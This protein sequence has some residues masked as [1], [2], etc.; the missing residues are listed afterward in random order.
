MFAGLPPVALKFCTNPEA[1]KTLRFEAADP[2]C[3]EFEFVA[4]G[5][6][7]GLIKDWHRSPGACSIKAVNEVMTQL[8]GIV[9]FAHRL[10]PPVVHGDLKPANILLQRGANGSI[11]LKVADFGIGGI[12]ASQD[13]EEAASSHLAPDA[14]RQPERWRPHRVV[15][16]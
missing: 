10:D 3:L 14:D 7:T 15:G 12:A 2:P 6:L 8:A 11:Q 9:G 1:A 5:D 4:G 16:G 13:L